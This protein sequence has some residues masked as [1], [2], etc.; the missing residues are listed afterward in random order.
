MARK[1]ERWT[2]RSYITNKPGDGET[3]L[4]QEDIFELTKNPDGS[5]TA[6]LVESRQVMSSE[7]KQRRVSKM[8][9]NASKIM[10]DYI[11]EHPESKIP[12][13]EYKIKDLLS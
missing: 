11:S 2:T 6:K 9:E 12:E 10:S 4:M 7:E 3:R 1:A 8:M 5:Y 13:G